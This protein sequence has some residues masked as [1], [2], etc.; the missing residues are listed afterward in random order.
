MLKI[1]KIK[2]AEIIP[3]GRLVLKPRPDQLENNDNDLYW[4]TPRDKNLIRDLRYVMRE[5]QTQFWSRFGVTQTRGS[6]FE[7]G[8]AI[9]LPVL[10]L[11]RLYLLRFVSDEDL[12]QVRARNDEQQDPV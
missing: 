7:R 3:A 11:I 9:P 10:L 6:R 12:A 4:I 2:N 1:D 8:G 5:N